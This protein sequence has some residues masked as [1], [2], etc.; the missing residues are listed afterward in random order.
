MTQDVEKRWRDPATFRSAVWYAAIVVTLALVVMAVAVVWG[1]AVGG[2]RCAEESFAVCTSPAK[3]ILAIGP[4][5]IL[6]IGGVGAL[7]Q[8][9]RVWRRGGSWPIW[10]G[11]GWG[12]LVVMIVFLMFSFGVLVS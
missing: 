9:Y 8:A 4:T 1:L 3:Q 10:Q 12:L 11:V 6:L 2:D 7:F 5:A